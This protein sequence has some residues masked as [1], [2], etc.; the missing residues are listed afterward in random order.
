M[1]IIT[2]IEHL[3]TY[4]FVKERLDNDRLYI[5]GWYYDIETG[6]IEYYDPDQYRFLPL[7]ALSRE[8]PS[9]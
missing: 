9:E 4:P 6:N 5:H 8:N 7:S 2:Q 3:M 1:S